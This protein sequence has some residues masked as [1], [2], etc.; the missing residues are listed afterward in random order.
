[1][2]NIHHCSFYHDKRCL[3]AYLYLV[4]FLSLFYRKHRLDKIRDY[5]WEKGNIL[6]DDTASLLSKSELN[7]F[8]Q[9]DQA[10]NSY[11]QRSGFDLTSVFLFK[12][13]DI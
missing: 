9:Y 11:M 13:I 10:L 4:D 6:S 1:M 12:I 7:F 8:H 5:R 2:M 3:F